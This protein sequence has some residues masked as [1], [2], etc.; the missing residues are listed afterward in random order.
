MLVLSMHHMLS[1]ENKKG[2]NAIQ[3]CSVEN[4]NGAIAV[5]FV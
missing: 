4:Q 5:D 1:A 3:W 2:V